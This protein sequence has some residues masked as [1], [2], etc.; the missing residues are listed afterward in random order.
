MSSR[1]RSSW[2]DRVR[3]EL[4]SIPFVRTM[5]RT[6]IIFLVV[7]Y[8]VHH[9]S[10]GFSAFAKGSPAYKVLYY[11]GFVH[12]SYL[13]LWSSDW[14]DF[15]S[16]C[17]HMNWIS[18]LYSVFIIFHESIFIFG[19]WLVISKEKLGGFY[20]KLHKVN[21]WVLSIDS[22]SDL[23]SMVGLV[24]E[25]FVG[26]YKFCRVPW[27]GLRFDFWL[28][29]GLLIKDSTFIDWVIFFDIIWCS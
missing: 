7:V 4:L 22:E 2:Y 11:G 26:F 28:T 16:D 9:E 18:V 20:L 15:W 29:L 19:N 5:P 8:F 23:G 1:S 25:W 12:L 10:D 3:L 14:D 24:I 27:C 6:C 17:H 21:F 13:E